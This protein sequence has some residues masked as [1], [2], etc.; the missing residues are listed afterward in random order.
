M[1][2]IAFNLEQPKEEHMNNKVRLIVTFNEGEFMLLKD[3][4]NNK[5]AMDY[6]RMIGFSTY[7]ATRDYDLDN[8][9]AIDP[10]IDTEKKLSFAYNKNHRSIFNNK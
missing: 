6:A 8:W 9:I 5:E 7:E 2:Y 3:F 1:G 10:T 4:D